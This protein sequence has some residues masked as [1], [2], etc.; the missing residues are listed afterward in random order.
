MSSRNLRLREKPGP[1][2]VWGPGSKSLRPDLRFGSRVGGVG[3]SSWWPLDV[4]CPHAVAT[5]VEVVVVPP[6]YGSHSQPNR[7]REN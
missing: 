5:W 1:E 3:M 2:L 7:E 6:G 4:W